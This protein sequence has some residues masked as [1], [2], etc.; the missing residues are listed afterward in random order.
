MPREYGNHFKYLLRQGRD[1]GGLIEGTDYLDF[2][3]LG[4]K[5]DPIVYG[6]RFKKLPL[7]FQTD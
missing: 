5:G 1:V 4:Y 3:K 7:R 2:K 6:G